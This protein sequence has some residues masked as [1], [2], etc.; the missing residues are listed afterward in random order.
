MKRFLTLVE[1]VNENMNYENFEDIPDDMLLG[2]TDSHGYVEFLMKKEDVNSIAQMGDNSQAVSDVI[3]TESYI[4]Y[5]LDK[6]SDEKIKEV[7]YEIVPDKEEDDE[8]LQ[9]RRDYEMYLIWDIAWSIKEDDQFDTEQ[10]YDDDFVQE[11]RS[12]M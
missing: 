2:Y 9:T 11:I 8:D 12:K 10:Q 5:Q 6:I 3:E 7:V 1:N 4:Q